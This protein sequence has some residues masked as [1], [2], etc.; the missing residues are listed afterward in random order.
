MNHGKKDYHHARVFAAALTNWIALNPDDSPPATRLDIRQPP[1]WTHTATLTLTERQQ[2]RILTVLRNDLAENRPGYTTPERAAQIID[3]LL[4]EL[5]AAG[6][7]R[8]T[9]ADLVEAA[10]RIG[11]SRR[12]IADHITTLL[13]NGRLAETRRPNTFRIT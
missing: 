6:R 13:D 9:T 3:G 4:T 10:P 1:N 12:W 7:T 11:R 2:Q 5:A 8:I